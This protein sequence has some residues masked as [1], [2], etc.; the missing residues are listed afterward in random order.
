MNSGT[1]PREIKTYFKDKR[2]YRSQSNFICNSQVTG[3]DSDVFHQ[4]DC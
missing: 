3:N 4:M 2:V 1:Y